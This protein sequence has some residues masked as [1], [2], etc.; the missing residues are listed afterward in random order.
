MPW[1][2]HGKHDVSFFLFNFQFAQG[3]ILKVA[4]LKM[5]HGTGVSCLGRAHEV[6]IASNCREEAALP[7]FYVA[8]R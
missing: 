6:R 4:I 3:R 5:H 2:R 8:L 1:I 7:A